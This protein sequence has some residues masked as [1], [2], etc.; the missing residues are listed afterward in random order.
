MVSSVLVDGQY[1]MPV[2]DEC[3]LMSEC[4]SSAYTIVKPLPALLV[5]EMTSEVF[6]VKIY[7][8]TQVVSVGH[9]TYSYV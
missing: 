2:L 1:G 8:S 6:I 4:S 7:D 5:N 9:I 3:G